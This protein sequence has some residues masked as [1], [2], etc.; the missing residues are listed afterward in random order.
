[1]LAV[2]SEHEHTHCNHEHS[3]HTPALVDPRR[4]PFRSQRA[5]NDLLQGILNATPAEFQ[6]FYSYCQLGL[7]GVGLKGA[8]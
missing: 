3:H 4:G 5:F 2:M 8:V 6:A 7:I 1:M